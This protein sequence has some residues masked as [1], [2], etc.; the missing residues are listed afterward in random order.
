MVCR[1]L[2]CGAVLLALHRFC[3]CWFS[4]G[5]FC[6]VVCNFLF[7]ASC[8]AAFAFPL[9]SWEL[10]SP[11]KII[12]SLLMYNLL[13]NIAF[14]HMFVSDR[15]APPCRSFDG[16]RG[17]PR[18]LSFSLRVP[19][20]LLRVLRLAL[21][22]AAFLCRYSLSASSLRGWVPFLGCLRWLTGF[23]ALL[24]VGVSAMGR[25]IYPKGGVAVPFLFLSS[26]SCLQRFLSETA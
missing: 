3:C 20:A 21:T 5:C 11:F 15:R 7:H 19:V 24:G 2:S 26:G 4:G 8:A 1:L 13:T 25:H 23:P 14:L 6:A 18:R 10:H 17:F 16:W 12:P 9:F 22:A